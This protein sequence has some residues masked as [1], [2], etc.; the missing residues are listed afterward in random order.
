MTN[1]VSRLPPFRPRARRCQHRGPLDVDDIPALLHKLE[2]QYK[3]D[4]YKGSFAW[5]DNLSEV[6]TKSLIDTLDNLLTAKIQTK[7]FDKT[8]L[9]VPEIIEWSDIA[10]FKYQKPKQGNLHDDIGWD[11]YLTFLGTVTPH[12]VETFRKQDIY[13]ISESSEQ[14]LHIWSVYRCIYCELSHDGSDYA[15]N[16][17]KWYKV[18]TDFFKKS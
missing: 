15:L 8:W 13:A 11:S 16:N 14:H 5:I 9:A 3:A 7:V 12:S 1:A 17:G 6:R 2:A 18:N 4:T 10:G